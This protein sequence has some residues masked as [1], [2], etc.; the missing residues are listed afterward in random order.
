[1]KAEQIIPILRIFDYQKTKE[2]YIDWLGFEI[3]W[4]HH[5]EDNTPVYM[6]VKKDNIVLHLSEHHGDGT[7][8]SRVFIWGEDIADYHK[9]LIDKK[10]KYNRPGLE[11]TFYDAISFKVDDPFGNKIIFNEKFDEEKHKDLNFYSIH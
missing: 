9:E 8:G 10:Y 5:F 3:V 4:E 11:K 1:M 6:E 2:F 7:P